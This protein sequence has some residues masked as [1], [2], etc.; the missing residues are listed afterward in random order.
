M[1]ASKI[2]SK[3][4]K[5][6]LADL[7][8]TFWQVYRDNDDRPHT[9]PSLCVVGISQSEYVRISEWIRKNRREPIK[10]SYN[11]V[12][13]FTN[14]L[15][16]FYDLELGLSFQNEAAM[17]RAIRMLKTIPQRDSVTKIGASS[18]PAV[19]EILKDANYHIPRREHDESD[20]DK[21]M[22]VVAYCDHRLSEED[23]MLLRFH[24][25]E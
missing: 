24:R 21:S 9:L 2:M 1:T 13:D 4:E 17:K 6:F 23:R 25:V 12:E 15:G 14:D 10:V 18:L 19:L 7:K 22:I 20:V 8:L 11:K 16:T 3:K 5:R